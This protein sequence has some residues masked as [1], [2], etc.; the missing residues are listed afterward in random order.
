MRVPLLLLVIFIDFVSLSANAEHLNSAASCPINFTVASAY[1]KVS[2][3]GWLDA[4][5]VTAYIPW[6]SYSPYTSPVCVFSISNNRNEKNT[7]L[8]VNLSTTEHLSK[9]DR[10]PDMQQLGING[11]QKR[12]VFHI[13]DRNGT[14]VCRI[15]AARV[16]TIGSPFFNLVGF[17]MVRNPRHLREW[18]LYHLGH[19]FQHMVLYDDASKPPLRALVSDMEGR[20]T[21]VNWSRMREH[22]S[23]QITA[24]QDFAIRFAPLA[25]WI[26]YLDDDW[27]FPA[28]GPAP[29]ETILAQRLRRNASQLIVLS[30]WHG[31][32][33]TADTAHRLGVPAALCAPAVGAASASAHLC[34]ILDA[35]GVPPH[36]LF[37]G[38]RRAVVSHYR[39]RSIDR[40][41]PLMSNAAFVA[42]RGRTLVA[43]IPHV[44]RDPAPG[45][46][47]EAID[48]S[49]YHFRHF[50]L[51]DFHNHAAKAREGNWGGTQGGFTSWL[52]MNRELCQVRGAGGRGAGEGGARICGGIVPQSCS[53]HSIHPSCQLCP[54]NCAHALALRRGGFAG[55]GWV[56]GWVGGSIQM[57]I[58]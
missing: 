20:V 12:I 52:A 22:G 24:M 46:T 15:S 56:G 10:I 38:R 34:D 44:W 40:G 7:F 27:F 47:P 23:R 54:A 30:S 3:H 53:L 45:A 17:S 43:H 19:V 2:E 14:G 16:A 33:T 8:S 18:L 5:L 57:L 51:L 48:A 58:R 26:V 29:L 37:S 41:R 36:L 49:A 4:Y 28:F 6:I 32:C 25:D 21:I 35:R 31:A 39:F 9:C 42:P 13:Q 50:K 1:F 11:S 55:V